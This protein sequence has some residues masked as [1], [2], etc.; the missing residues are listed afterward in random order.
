[1]CVSYIER[2]C[3]NYEIRKTVRPPH[4]RL[5]RALGQLHWVTVNANHGGAAQQPSPGRERGALRCPVSVRCHIDIRSISVF[6]YSKH[7]SPQRTR[8]ASM[9]KSI[10]R[11]ALLSTTNHVHSPHMRFSSA[12]HLVSSRAA[13]PQNSRTI[14][15]LTG[16]AA[17]PEPQ[18]A[19]Q[20]TTKATQAA[21]RHVHNCTSVL[22]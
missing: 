9:R 3:L 2:V 14:A 20:N 7:P 13:P 8:G 16:P 21:S 6:R 4:C 19:D 10:M 22:T 18:R 11:P 1:M 5:V 17:R 12:K 15:S